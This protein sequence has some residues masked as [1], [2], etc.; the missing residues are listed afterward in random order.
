VRETNGRNIIDFH[1]NNGTRIAITLDLLAS[2]LS[3][4]VGGEGRVRGM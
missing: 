1:V 4:V 3:L 2:I